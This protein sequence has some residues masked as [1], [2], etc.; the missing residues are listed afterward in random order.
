MSTKRTV[1]TEEIQTCDCDCKAQAADLYPLG[2]ATTTEVNEDGT[3][4]ITYH[5]D[6]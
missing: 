6:V 1:S 5:D 4:T 2:V 3:A